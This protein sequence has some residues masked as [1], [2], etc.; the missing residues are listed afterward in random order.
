[1]PRLTPVERERAIGII[2]QANVTPSVIAQKFQCNVRPIERLR[3]RFRQ[4]GT[5]SDHLRL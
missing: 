1:M 2:L 5:T 4:T 3:N